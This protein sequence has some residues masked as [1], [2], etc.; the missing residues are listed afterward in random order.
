MPNTV[1]PPAA[2]PLFDTPTTAAEPSMPVADLAAEL[3][4][5]PDAPDSIDACLD[6][7]RADPAAAYADVQAFWTENGEQTEAE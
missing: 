5:V 3:M 1:T 7:A 6:V 4:V 2:D